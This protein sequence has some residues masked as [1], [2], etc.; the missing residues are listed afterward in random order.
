MLEGRR[1]VHQ[2]M[3]HGVLAVTLTVDMLVD[4]VPL[5]YKMVTR[6]SALL[7]SLLPHCV[8]HLLIIPFPTDCPTYLST[9]IQHYTSKDVH[10]L[11]P[12]PAS[13]VPSGERAWQS[14]AKSLCSSAQP[15]LVSV[16]PALCLTA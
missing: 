7:A 14:T 13:W 8:D 3:E 10:S 1:L 6:E 12:L 2:C 9:V 11:L 16:Q 4:H 15:Q 5:R